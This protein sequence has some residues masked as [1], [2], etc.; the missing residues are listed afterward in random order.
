MMKRLTRNY[1]FDES[2][3]ISACAQRFDGWRF[4]ED[5][6]FNPDVALSYFF[7]TGLWDATRE[8]LLATFFVLARAFRWSLEYEPNHG[9]YWRAYRTL[10]LSLCGES[11][12]EKYKHSA[13]H[14]EWIITFAP[15]LADHLRRVAEIHY[16]T[17]KLLQMVD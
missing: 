17:R 8:E 11:V 7:E 3:I 1:D 2:Q 15:R 12:T 10:F 4:I 14:D 5:T 6:G 16:Q 13:L 9:R